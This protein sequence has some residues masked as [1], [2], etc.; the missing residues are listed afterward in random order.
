MIKLARLSGAVFAA[1]L[2]L[3]AFPGAT[4]SQE[5]TS[6]SNVVTEKNLENLRTDFDSFKSDLEQKLKEIE[7]RLDRI[8]SLLDQQKHPA[9]LPEVDDQTGYSDLEWCCRHINHPAP[10]CR[11][12]VLPRRCRS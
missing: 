4:G 5:K 12:A 2:L 10:C 6:P 9:R 7:R 8:E 3:C 11:Y 1:M